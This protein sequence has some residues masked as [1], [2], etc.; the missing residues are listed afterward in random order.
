MLNEEHSK[1]HINLFT[2]G[3]DR[4]T[5]PEMSDGKK[6]FYL[7]ATNMAIRKEGGK[8]FTLQSI[9]GVNKLYD[10]ISTSHNSHVNWN[11]GFSGNNMVCIGAC[12]C[13]G[14]LVEFF[15]PVSVLANST[16]PLIR[17]DGKIMCST[18]D[19]GFQENYPLQIDVE[20]NS[21][22]LLISV[23]DFNIT[24][25]LF[26]LTDIINNFNAGTQKY[27]SEFN[28]ADYQAILQVSPDHPVFD[29][30]G[31]GNLEYG[32]Y[33][34]AIRYVDKTGNVTNWSVQTP[35]IPI[36]N[37]FVS[38]SASGGSIHYRGNKIYGGNVGDTSSS[39]IKLKFRVTNVADYSYMQ[40][41]RVK[42]VTGTSLEEIPIAQVANLPIDIT[43]DSVNY[44]IQNW[45]D[46]GDNAIWIDL[47]D[48][49]DTSNLSTI[50]AAKTTRFYSNRLT[51][52]NI[53]KPSMDLTGQI[54]FYTTPI[55]SKLAVPIVENMGTA[56]NYDDGSLGHKDVWNQVYRKAL[57]HGEKYGWGIRFMDS[58]GNTS[59]VAPYETSADKSVGSVP[60][61]LPN[62]RDV[63][64]GDS[65]TLSISPVVQAADINNT[66]GNATFE[67]F[68]LNLTNGNSFKSDIS[69]VI[70]Y[71]ESETYNPL[72]PVNSKDTNVTGE[73]YA[74]I[75]EVQTEMDT[76]DITNDSRDTYK[77]QPRGF[78]PEY[79]SLGMAFQGVKKMPSWAKSF[80]I[81]RTKP[82][83]RVIAQGIGIYKLTAA[84]WK[85]TIPDLGIPDK[86][87]SKDLYKLTTFFP[88]LNSGIKTI[89]INN[90]TRYKI[91]F[92]SPVGY[93]SELYSDNTT[94]RVT[95][96]KDKTTVPYPLGYDASIDL[97]SYARVL[98]DDP[99][100]PNE[101][102]NP[103]LTSDNSGTL[104]PYY[105][106]FGKWRNDVINNGWF[107]GKNGNSAIDVVNINSD[108]TEIE[109][110]YAIY[111]KQSTDNFFGSVNDDGY[112]NFYEPF[113]IINI[114]DEAAELSLSNITEYVET[115]H[116]QKLESI[117]GR[118]NALPTTT[119]MSFN[120]VDERWEDCCVDINSPTYTTDQRYLFVNNRRY[121]NV[122]YYLNKTTI[123]SQIQNNGFA[124]ISDIDAD[125]NTVSYD[126]YGTYDYSFDAG[127][128][129]YTITFTDFIPAKN[130]LIIVKYDNRIPIKLFAG[131]TVV[132]ENIFCPINTK[133]KSDGS[134]DNQFLALLG[135]PYYR[136][137]FND[138][139]KRLHKVDDK[140]NEEED[141]NFARLDYIRQ[142]VIMFCCETKTNVPILYN[143][144]SAGGDSSDP[145]KGVFSG[146]K[147]FPYI[148]YVQRPVKWDAG[149]PKNNF[150]SNKG[151]LYDKY[152]EDFP[153]EFEYGGSYQNWNYGGFYFYQNTNIDYAKDITNKKYF[154]KP[155]VGFVE[156]SNFPD[157]II[158]SARRDVNQQSLPNYKTF[159][160]DAIFD[161]EE[162]Y[163]EI[164]YLYDNDSKHGNNLIIVCNRGIGLCVTEK[165]ILSELTGNQLA[166]INPDNT[167]ISNILW[168]S[169]NVG[170]IDEMW[171]GIAEYNNKIFIPNNKDVY[172][173]DESLTLQP[174]GSENKGGYYSKLLPI[175]SSLRNGYQTSMS[176]IY[177]ITDNE[178][179]LNIG[180]NNVRLSAVKKADGGNADLYGDVLRLDYVAQ[181]LDCIYIYFDSSYIVKYGQQYVIIYNL[182]NLPIGSKVSI[183]KKT[184]L[185]VRIYS[186][187]AADMTFY[188]E[189]PYD[190][191]D[192]AGS[193]FTRDT[194]DFGYT[195][196]ARI[197]KGKTY[198]YNNEKQA[199]IGEFDYDFEKYVNVYS[200]EN[201]NIYKI[202]GIRNFIANKID[203]NTLI[204]DYDYPNYYSRQMTCSVQF[205]V[206]PK[207]ILGFT[208]ELIN[209]LINSNSKPMKIEFFDNVD[210]NLLCYLDS[211]IHPT[212]YLKDYLGGYYQQ[213]PRKRIDLTGNSNRLQNDVFYI[214]IIGYP[215]QFLQIKEVVNSY[216]LLK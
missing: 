27:F 103:N 115:G 110:K 17:V 207:E 119:T 2:N 109:L 183:I 171:R 181:D 10:F 116:L 73:N 156:K 5:D 16:Y 26:D 8:D 18:S 22:S 104:K 191:Y 90:P 139:Y 176:S 145:E 174:I 100:D 56:S 123:I 67:V 143:I 114:I 201:Y 149:T 132:G 83:G 155:L 138:N 15:V 167:F 50:T 168:L 147:C 36:I 108:F 134:I 35:L 198:C 14:H 177:N 55:E 52:A 4:D 196:S 136:W 45:T 185:H 194:S 102:I 127:M 69:S 9:K 112:R 96:S 128:R 187:V 179:W 186:Q 208:K 124:T 78:T 72:T 40:I 117:I 60:V 215:A 3:A 42:Y 28:P 199:W 125:G 173:L 29:D 44:T 166:T 214:R 210:G 193:T 162:Q 98:Y 159:Y 106:Q 49:E 51:Y 25:Y 158:Y 81:V 212:K 39:G 113:Y 157:R 153:R 87:C 163:G 1:K 58:V 150:V 91:Q 75:V 184:G 144:D 82:V 38:N 77:Y 7:D 111:S 62:R 164:K 190:N 79:R 88:D 129:N 6:G 175:L 37:Q 211:S 99:T 47:T 68:D 178:Y 151:A 34:Y 92:L 197:F 41:R 133:T 61:A 63:V 32:E 135:L 71:N 46:I 11:N 202:I 142:W 126:I 93:F 200:I 213:V 131:D 192:S 94:F 209:I 65:S 21:D 101:T 137:R 95:T 118:S 140:S 148:N 80:S 205:A 57:L 204:L 97:I 182:P 188:I 85:P 170:C 12:Y 13:G 172:L 48:I 206:S 165:T 24:P 160:P 195:Q 130:S 59:F 31:S 189:I 23:T 76:G 152:A 70:A 146:K 20:E 122:T 154:S 121:L 86:K 180:E 89:D 53:K 64:S 74:T 66:T 141:R 120:L 54:S 203:S 107:H 169:K 105:A 30:Y 216:K 19:L 33:T 161:A 84:T 43:Q